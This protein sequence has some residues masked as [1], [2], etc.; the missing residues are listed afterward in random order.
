MQLR[1]LCSKEEAA[2]FPKERGSD[3]AQLSCTMIPSHWLVPFNKIQM[4]LD[5]PIQVVAPDR[6][7]MARGTLYLDDGKSFDYKQ[8]HKVYVEITWD[9]G[10]LES[11]LIESGVE[12]SASKLTLGISRH[13]HCCRSL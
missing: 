1:Y 11:K 12:I 9:N 3:A 10:R 5:L 6:Q 13:L 4:H 7:G 8:G 2:L